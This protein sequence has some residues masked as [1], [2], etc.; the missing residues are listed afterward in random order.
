MGNDQ[1]SAALQR[2]RNEAAV[3]VVA[4]I[5]FG[6][7]IDKPDVRFVAHVDLP[8]SLE[9]YYQETGRA[10]R[11]G[12]AAVAWML[13]GPGD[14]PQ[15]RRF[16]DDS[17]A[18]EDQKRVEHGKLEALI[19]Y[20]EAAGCRRQVLLRH[21]GE[22]LAQPCGNCDGCLEPKA[23]VDL[24]VPAQKLL[25]AVVRTGARFGAA[26]VVD[27]LLGSSS[28]RIRQLGHDQLSVHGIGRELDRGQWR[29]LVHQLS[30][31][32][33]LQP[34]PDGKGGLQLGAPER[35]RPLLRGELV[36]ELP[37]PPPQKESRQRAGQVHARAQGAIT[38]L[39]EGL[40]VD[41]ALLTALKG[42]RREQARSQGVPP[43][44]VFH[45]R[46]LVELAARRPTDL[47]ALSQIGGIGAAKLE[48]YGA[49]LLAVLKS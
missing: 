17:A 38:G 43:Y 2:F 40:E 7:G 37:L 16:I 25:S 46:T 8:K 12:L 41:E 22:T 4:T 29:T 21:F 14:I 24:T 49:G 47:E 44:V 31:L 48:R 3:V 32:G 9:A 39:D 18:P 33:Y 26:H 10:G 28:E 20:S 23:V 45:D 13:H 5:A 34:V 42:W 35:V 15:L 11:D 30:G 6:M 19:A 36:L 1:R 27:V